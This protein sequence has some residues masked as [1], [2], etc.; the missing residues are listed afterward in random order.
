MSS[1]R[2]VLA[3]VALAFFR[4]GGLIPT[5]GSAPPSGSFKNRPFGNGVGALE[6]GVGGEEMVLGTRPRIQDCEDL[7]TNLW[8]WLV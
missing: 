5:P 4:E 1:P 2:A 6:G 3:S 8:R 7:V